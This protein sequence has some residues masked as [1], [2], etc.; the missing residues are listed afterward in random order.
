[1][2]YDPDASLR[3]VEWQLQTI[4]GSIGVYVALRWLEIY[5]YLPMVYPRRAR[6][7]MLSWMPCEVHA[8]G[9]KIVPNAPLFIQEVEVL[10]KLDGYFLIEL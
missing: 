8:G 10:V 3:L 7:M 1:M 9:S 2:G 5:L 6:E 4:W